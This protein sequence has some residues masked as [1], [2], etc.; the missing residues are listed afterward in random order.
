MVSGEGGVG[1]CRRPDEE[2]DRRVIDAL[3]DGNLDWFD[4][5]TDARIDA[6]AGFG[7]HEIRCWVAATAAMREMGA[8]RLHLDYYRLVPEWIT[9][10][11]LMSTQPS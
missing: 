7:G 11:G 4:A 3:R 6:H 9:G 8:P 10:M 2:W 1:P 5:L